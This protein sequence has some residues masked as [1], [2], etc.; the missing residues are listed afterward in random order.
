MQI[1]GATFSVLDP[2]YPPARQTIYLEVAQPR[3]LVNIGRAT[4]ESG[5]LATVVRTFIDTHLELKAEV[6]S[7]RLGDDGYLSGVERG[8]S[9]VFAEARAKAASPLLVQVGPD[10]IP[11]LSFTSGRWVQFWLYLYN[12]RLRFL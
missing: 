1:S 11:T 10:S 3:A 8:Q 5:P 2:A 6:P 7:L 12:L 9:D 4:E